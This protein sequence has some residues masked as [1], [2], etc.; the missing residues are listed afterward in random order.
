MTQTT[1]DP[2]VEPTTEPAQ[3]RDLPLSL[4]LIAADNLPPSSIAC[5]MARKE[6][7]RDNKAA[8]LEKWQ[9]EAG[10]LEKKR[11]ADLAAEADEHDQMHAAGVPGHI[12]RR[13]REMETS[14]EKESLFFQEKL[15]KLRALGFSDEDV[16]WVWSRKSDDEDGDKS[17]HT[18]KTSQS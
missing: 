3:Q 2:E 10:M 7:H 16:A 18:A 6:A 12:M 5:S 11:M 9:A 1:D 4:A 8:T 14:F 13:F 17:Y 15:K